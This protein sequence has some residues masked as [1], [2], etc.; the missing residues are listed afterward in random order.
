MKNAIFLVM[1]VSNC[2][3]ADEWFCTQEAGK[4]EGNTIWACGIGESTDEA[5]ARR[6]ALK[7]AHREFDDICQMSD[8][9]RGKES[10]VDPQRTSCEA[11]RGHFKCHRM[12]M[13]SFKP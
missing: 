2:A 1:F 6:L 4:R 13:V 7:D 5:N 8:D 10:S 12:I 9:C 3:K 11:F